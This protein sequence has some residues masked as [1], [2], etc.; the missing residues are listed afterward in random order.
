MADDLKRMLSSATINYLNSSKRTAQDK[1]FSTLEDFTRADP[2][3]KRLVV[4]GC[5]GSGKSTLLTVLGGWRFVQSKETD[6][7]F[8]WQPKKATGE[9]APEA[10]AIFESAASS[11]SVTKKTSFANVRFRGEEERELIVVDTPGHD[12]PAG[13]DID[14]QEAR[15]VLGAIAADLP[16]SSR[17][18]ARCRPSSCSTTTSSR[19]AS[20][21]RRTRS[22]R[23]SRRSS[24][25]RRPPCGSTS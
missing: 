9:D 8:V 17:R 25:R 22:S 23:W 12:D 4:I 10:E 6:Y 24:R 1:L 7:Q 15:D 5:T 13:G 14:S 20:T 18:S 21:P 16:T 2:N 3:K 11:D 19:T